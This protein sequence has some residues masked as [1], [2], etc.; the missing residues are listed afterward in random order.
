MQGSWGRGAGKGEKR[1]AWEGSWTVPGQ[2]RGP[3]EAAATAGMQEPAPAP[4]TPSH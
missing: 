3:D 4:P 2:T 1:E